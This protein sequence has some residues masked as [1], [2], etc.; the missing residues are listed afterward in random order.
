MRL[1]AT[2][3]VKL[4]E[5]PVTVTVV[6]PVV[7]VPFAVR[8]SVLL[9]EAGLGLNAAVSPLGSPAAESVTLPAKP[10]HGVIV[11]ALVP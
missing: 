1:I 9:L 2:V 10:F 8:V 3:C 7:A 6:I 5:L 11:I 4:P